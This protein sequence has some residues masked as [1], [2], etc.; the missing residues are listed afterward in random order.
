MCHYT[1]AWV[2]SRLDDFVKPSGVISHTP[3]F[4][5]QFSVGDAYFYVYFLLICYADAA[6]VA[7]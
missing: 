4:M 6:D 7:M 3:L 2:N 5:L 1:N